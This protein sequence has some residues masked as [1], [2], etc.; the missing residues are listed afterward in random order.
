MVEESLFN[1]KENAKE[2]SFYAMQYL[3]AIK[4]TKLTEYVNAVQLKH[5]IVF[6]E[7]NYPFF[8][9][10]GLLDIMKDCIICFCTFE[11]KDDKYGCTQPEC[12]TKVCGDCFPALITF[13]EK[14]E[15]LPKCPDKK[16][17]GIYTLSTIG[18]GFPKNVMALY[19]SA[20]LKFM[21]KDQGDAVKKRIQEEEIVAKIRDQRLQY[22]EAEYPTAVALVAKIAFKNK[23]RHLDRQRTKLVNAQVNKANRSCFNLICNGFLDPNYVCMMCSTEFCRMCEKKVKQG[24]VCKQEDLDSVNLVNNMIK[25]PGC[26][27]PVFKDQ[28]C[29]SITCSNCGTLFKYSTG[30]R[31]GHGSANVKLAKNFSMQ[32]K[33]RLSDI[34]SESLDQDCMELLLRL[35]ALEPPV[36]NKRI[37]LHPLKGYLKDKD[38]INAGKQIAKKIDEYYKFKVNYKRV[39]VTLAK[40]EQLIV[41]K[42]PLKELKI[43]LEQFINELTRK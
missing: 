23:L 10:L 14:S 11:K 31:G 3:L 15:I 22:L 32:N 18:Y 27:L 37:I 9:K 26:K 12:E 28:G 38:A 40:V 17:N 35:E 1:A 36:K 21:M 39:Y 29:D 16:C 8:L 41:D 20:C 25:C 2:S 6:C 7:F 34:F 13:S 30:E 5:I 4:C 24:H 19:H 43:N 33:E 42:T